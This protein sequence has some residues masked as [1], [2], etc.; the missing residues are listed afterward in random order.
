MLVKRIDHIENEELGKVNGE[1][2]DIITKVNGLE[3]QLER[4]NV[5]TEKNIETSK[6]LSNTMSTIKDTMVS[7]GKAIEHSNVVSEN[8]SNSINKLSG[9]VEKV[10][11]KF[12]NKIIDIGERVEKID[13]K[14]KIDIAEIQRDNA[15]AQIGKYFIGGG[16][17]VAIGAFV[18]ELIKLFIK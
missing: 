1:I 8:L 15:K 10:D 9:Q 14:S 11:S 6:E 4:N 12:E 2:K 7:M 16:I 13:N 17:G 5:L 18:I 3:V